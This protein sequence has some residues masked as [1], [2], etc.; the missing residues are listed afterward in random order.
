[1]KTFCSLLA[2][3]AAVALAGCATPPPPQRD[4]AGIAPTDFTV[5]VKC[6]E[7]TMRFT[8]MIVS[9]GQCEN[10]VGIGGGTYHASGHEVVCAFRKTTGVAGQISLAVSRAGVRLGDSTTDGKSGGVRAELLFAPTQE[11]AL[12][13]TY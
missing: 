3:I 11:H 5:T 6:S 10:W 7:P 8:G 9:D 2:L 1:M 12:F 13:T 4:F